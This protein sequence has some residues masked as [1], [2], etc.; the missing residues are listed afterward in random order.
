MKKTTLLLFLFAI[1]S[2]NLMASF[3]VNKKNVE[4]AN[5]KVK[6]LIDLKDASK[7]SEANVTIAPEDALSP[8]V[9]GSE[10]DTF[11]ITILLW[12]FL[13]G[14]AGH[15]WYAKK[16]TGWNILFILTLGGLGVWW[17][18]DGINILTKNF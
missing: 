14:L 12:F 13:G 6:S 16:P 1:G 4:K 15:R 11:I 2:M 17:L 3:P 5:A 10:D 7:V 9:A 18:I 8:A